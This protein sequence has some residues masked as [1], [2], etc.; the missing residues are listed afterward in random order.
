MNKI[1]NN[2]AQATDNKWLTPIAIAYAIIM[3]A[4]MIF[5]GIASQHADMQQHTITS[6]QTMQWASDTSWTKEW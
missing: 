5:C 4:W 2:I 3:L 6:T 1:M